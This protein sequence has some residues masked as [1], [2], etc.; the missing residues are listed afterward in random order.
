MNQPKPLRVIVMTGA[1]AGLGA[2][3]LK[4]IAAEPDTRVIVGA[5]GSGRDVPKGVEVIPLDLASLASVREFADTVIAKLGETRIESLVLN[6]GM[7]APGKERRSADGY[8]LTFAVNHLAHYLLARL[9]APYLAEQGR[10]VITTSDTHD[11]AITPIAPKS[12]DPQELAHP[13]KNQGVRAYSSSKLCNLLTVQSF[14]TQDALKAR[15]INVI[16]FNPG[17]TGGTSLGRDA[18]PVMK[19]ILPLLMHTLFRVVG[20]FKPEYVMGTAERSGEVLA[21]V[22]L[23][24]VAP[25][26]G[27]LYLSLVQGKI[28]FP[29]PSELAR[30]RDAQKLLWRESADMVGLENGSAP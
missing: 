16:A 17:L 21:E 22:A 25:P 3:A 15:G 27:R 10:L 5:R 14:A 12:L 11:P 18:P 4:H 19:V 6:A 24:S 1:T 2:H 23:G 13:T 8:E 29:D 20:L 26:A 7:Q 28:T 30:S 9:L